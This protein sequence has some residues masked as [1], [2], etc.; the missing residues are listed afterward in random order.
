MKHA[1]WVMMLVV[2]L[3]IAQSASAGDYSYRHCRGVGLSGLASPCC[4]F[5]CETCPPVGYPPM[6]APIG[7]GMRPWGPGM[8]HGGLGMPQ[9]AMVNPGPPTAAITYPYYTVRGPRDFFQKYPTP[10]G[11]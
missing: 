6:R 5:A 3:G 4:G 9:G 8:P 1:M 11:P 2:G 10:I 7:P